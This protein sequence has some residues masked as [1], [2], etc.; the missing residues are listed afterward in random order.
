MWTKNS[1]TLPRIEPSVLFLLANKC[2][3]IDPVSE[4]TFPDGRIWRPAFFPPLPL[5][6]HETA[7]SCGYIF[8]HPPG[9]VLLPSHHLRASA[10]LCVVDAPL[11]LS[12]R[13]WKRLAERQ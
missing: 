1:V 4:R 9:V 3:L 13:G 12:L 11:S 10:N 8:P 2:S 5:I 6:P 7:I